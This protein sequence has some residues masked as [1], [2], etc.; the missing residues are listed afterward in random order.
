MDEIKTLTFEQYHI[1][2]HNITDLVWTLLDKPELTPDDSDRLVSAAYAARFHHGEFG[3]PLDVARAEWH[4][5]RVNLKVQ[6][7]I[8]ALYHGQKCLEICRDSELEP[9]TIAYAYEALA[10]AAAFIGD[11]DATEEY[12]R[13]G[14]QFGKMI[15]KEEEKNMF[16][17]DLSTVPGYKEMLGD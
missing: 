5:A 3:D 12:L 15:E 16:F 10:R 4:L 6:R 8:P 17:A 2:A 14:R 13:L 1:I 7:P 9:F 11:T